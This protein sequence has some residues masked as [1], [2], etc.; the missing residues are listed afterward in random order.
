MSL[1][2]DP[3]SDRCWVSGAGRPLTV[4]G[5][6][7]AMPSP[8][9]RAG[10]IDAHRIR[11]AGEPGW[12]CGSCCPPTSID[13]FSF[14][15]IFAA[16]VALGVIS[17]VPGGLGVFEIVVFVSLGAPCARNELAAALLIYRAVYFVL[18]LM[19]AAAALAT[20]E[21]RS[22]AASAYRQP[23]IACCS[24]PTCSRQRFSAW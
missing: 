20:F 19:L 8:A 23:E 5:F 2:T 9:H 21:L 7:I 1:L 22:D 14:A 18:P 11:S 10:P 24:A 6:S 4:A 15:A 3:G 12:R 17:R 16:A 13:L